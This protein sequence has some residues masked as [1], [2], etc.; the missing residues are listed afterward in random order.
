[1]LRKLMSMFKSSGSRGGRTT[2]GTSGTS[3]GSGGIGAKISSAVE[4]FFRS[5][6]R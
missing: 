1:M 5:R 3:G 6:R 2:G 4:R